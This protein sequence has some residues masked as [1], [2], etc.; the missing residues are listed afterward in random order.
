MA[1]NKK[2]LQQ[3]RDRDDHCWHCG[4]EVD[5]VPHHRINR[6]MG[7]SKLLDTADNLIMVC[8]IYNGAMESYPDT[9]RRA[10]QYNHKLPVWADLQAPV[11]D[12]LTGW[13]YLFRD[14][15]KMRVPDKDLLGF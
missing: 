10:R 9:A 8:A 12:V 4:S 1:L 15:T 3:V 13:W 11:Y 2:L 5:L 14:G 6:G 7:G